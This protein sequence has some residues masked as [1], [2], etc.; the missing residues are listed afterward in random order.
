MTPILEI[1]EAGANGYTVQGISAQELALT[2][3]NL[4]RGLVQCEPDVAARLFERL[5]YLHTI[6]SVSGN[7]LT[8]REFEILSWIA[9]GYSNKQIASTLVI[10]LR[11]V[12][13]H[14]HNI[15]DKLN[16]SRRFEAVN[17]A[18]QQDGL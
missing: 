1:I 9:K 4:K 16:V 15:L 10:E 11:T 2:I 12:K 8:P 7:H 17:I 18:M 3:L 13:H 5:T 6:Q 14:V